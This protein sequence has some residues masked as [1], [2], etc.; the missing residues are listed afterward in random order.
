MGTLLVL[1]TMDEN[2]VSSDEEE[3]YE[4]D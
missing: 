2:D 1:I 4:D 3:E